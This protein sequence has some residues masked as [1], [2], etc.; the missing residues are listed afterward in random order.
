[1]A[2]TDMA[3]Y[4]A[5]FRKR[6]GVRDIPVPDS[7]FAEDVIYIIVIKKFRFTFNLKVGKTQKKF[8]VAPK[9]VFRMK[10]TQKEILYLLLIRFISGF[11]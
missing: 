6:S 5:Y 4:F 10:A 2:C 1:M 7:I 11:A 9:N 3:V 8:S